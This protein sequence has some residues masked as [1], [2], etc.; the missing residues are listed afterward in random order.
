MN[1]IRLIIMAGGLATRWDNYLNRPKHLIRIN[2]ETLLERQ[3]R[4]YRSHGVRD[5]VI[6]GPQEIDLR[7]TNPASRTIFPKDGLST[8][9]FEY[10]LV[11]N[12]N[13]W[14]F[15]FTGARRAEHFIISLGDVFMSPLLVKTSIQAARCEEFA[16]IA[17][18]GYD[19]HAEAKRFKA[20]WRTWG[21]LWTITLRRGLL[22]DFLRATKRCQL[23]GLGTKRIYPELVRLRYGEELSSHFDTPCSH[24]LDDYSIDFDSPEIYEEWLHSHS[25]DIHLL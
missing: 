22:S 25:E 17:K 19:H 20:S 6:V 5:I 24:H 3:I 21:E 12:M 16:W 10:R 2:G 7:Y 4:Q 11:E 14:H 23:D 15:L 8:L 9:P 13:L 18:R 1:Q